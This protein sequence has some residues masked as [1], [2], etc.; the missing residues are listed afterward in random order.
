MQEFARDDQMASNIGTKGLGDS[1]VRI[2]YFQ[3][4]PALVRRVLTPESTAGHFKLPSGKE[5]EFM[6]GP[7]DIDHT[8]CVVFADE[9]GEHPWPERVWAA[10]KHRLGLN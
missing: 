4:D 1:G 7:F 8:T 6:L 2:F 9:S 5:V 3:T 10:V